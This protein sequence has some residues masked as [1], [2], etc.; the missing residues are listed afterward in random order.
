MRR[1]SD[2]C[3]RRWTRL[4]EFTAG[5]AGRRAV[6]RAAGA[7]LVA[8]VFVAGG[9]GSAGHSV[10]HYPSFYPHEIRIETLDPAAAATRL[11]DATLH[12]YLGAAPQFAGLVPAHLRSARSLGSFLVLSFDNAVAAFASVEARCRAA[13]SIA[14]AIGKG[15]VES[16]VFHPYPITPFHSDYLHHLDRADAARSAI[17]TASSP[18][19]HKV[20]ARGA[21]AEA[22]VKAHGAG[23]ADG[24]EITLEEISIDALTATA[25][26]PF[27]G[28]SGLPWVKEGWFQAYRLLAPHLNPTRRQ[29]A[30]EAY[31]HLVRG[32]TIGFAE[33][34]DLERNLI[35][36]LTDGCERVVV[37]FA[38]REEYF[39]DRYPEGIE[40]VAFDS[41]AGLNSP[42]FL[43]TVKLKE[44]P[45]NGELFL[46]MPQPAAAAWNPVAGFSDATGR[47]LWSAVGDPAM[48]H[49]PFN[50]SWMPNRAQSVVTRI[51]GQSGGIKVPEDAI[52][53]QPGT[54]ASQPVGARTVA[55]A[56]VVYD[57]LASPY[58]DG[59]EMDVA[60]AIYPFSFLY[61][62]GSKSATN[63]TY[64]PRLEATFAAIQERLAGFKVL[65]VE[66]S[67]HQISEDMTI[68][69]KTP[70]VELYLRN[71]PGEERQISALAPPWSTV[72][73]HL[74]ALMEEAVS[75]G[76]AAFSD[77]EARRRSVPWLDLVRDP[78]LRGRL[79]DLVRQFER[80]GFRPEV[81]K[82]HV[83][84][85]EARAR[86]RSL[87]SFAETK[88][89]FL[90]ANGPYRLKQWT[91]DTVVLEAV[92]EMTYP[93]GFGT[94]DRFVNPPRAVIESATR[95]GNTIVAEASAEML[96]KG[97]R[98]YRAT[99]EPLRRTTMRGVDGLLVVSRYLLIGP[100][101]KVLNVDKMQWGEDGRFTIAIPDDLPPG[102]YTV[103]LAVFLDGNSTLP[104]A[105]IVRFR[106]GG[107][108]S[109]G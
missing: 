71:V 74:L 17:E 78:Q 70:V 12:A 76:Y 108:N 65:R 23:R 58:E 25:G 57:V 38:P 50:A 40:N 22:I 32:E 107:A 61:R 46:G 75:R 16:F 30:D 59:S 106:V 101:G 77:D 87:R 27:D 18:T 92:R 9:Q 62:W 68:I 69:Q 48:I 37:G 72:P 84:D 15:Q 41:V 95:V 36:S 5:H 85:D 11:N 1:G 60:D 7:V 8:G 79:L 45:W 20:R 43:R 88:G 64:E 28:W 19:S 42:V 21:L 97:G 34:V 73:W 91:P 103:I 93:L 3:A 55:S 2:Q 4:R 89:H 96:L 94:F 35:A 26:L 102:Q 10:G 53:P 52:R 100:D 104:S 109:R 54:G 105:K 39:D 33:R 13:Q 98:G 24:A 80:E 86:W 66:R 56:K 63:A 49:F 44:Y 51:E 67:K 90:V 82:G 6:R 83:S 81:L 29:A 47:L 14:A 31:E 99:K